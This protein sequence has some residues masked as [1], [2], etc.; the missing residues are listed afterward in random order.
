MIVN[1]NTMLFARSLRL[2]AAEERIDT[3]LLAYV[4]NLQFFVV[5]SVVD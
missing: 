3:V 2:L 4:A 5:S 1:L